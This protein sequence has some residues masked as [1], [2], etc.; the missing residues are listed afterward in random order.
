[1]SPFFAGLLVALT[2]ALS[3]GPGLMLYFH[4][5]VRRGFVAGLAVLAGLWISD[6]GFITI[7][8][9]GTAQLLNTVHNQHIAAIVCASILLIFGLMQW[10][11]NPIA[12]SRPTSNDIVG[13]RTRLLTDVLSGFLI[14]TSNPFVFIFWMTVV[15]IAGVNFG[16]RTQSF[17]TFF[18]GLVSSAMFL[19]TTKCFVFS[20]I[21]VHF[22]STALKWIN[23]V[24]GGLLLLAA[25]VI[26]YKAY[27]L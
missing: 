19:D 13:K 24:V 20:K 16:V 22:N 11:K 25:A 10:T 21:T 27:L 3:V 2:M 17:Y 6:F 18:I 9:L 5:S 4:A 26:L 1:M 14:N 12:A 23:R 7:C 15:G 8:Y